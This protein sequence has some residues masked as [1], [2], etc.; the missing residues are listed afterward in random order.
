M[1]SHAGM[2]CEEVLALLSDYLDG[3]LDAKGLATVEAH[4]H[5]CDGCTRFGGQLRAT[6]TALREHL[7][8]APALPERVRER[9]RSLLRD[10][11]E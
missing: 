7:R 8:S 6:V 11:P 4:L 1:S 3:E 9:L 2:T 10:E 5:A